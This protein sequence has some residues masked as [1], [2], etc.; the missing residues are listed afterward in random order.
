[1]RT[2][3]CS[4]TRH[5][6]PEWFRRGLARGG[7]SVRTGELLAR[8][9]LHTVCREARCPN[10]NE[11]FSRRVATFLILGDRCTR[12]CAFCNVTDHRGALPAPD[13][14]EPARLA[15]A[16]R[17]LDL[18][19]VVVT[20]VTRDDLADGG[21]AHF[22]AVITAVRAALPQAGIEVLIPD[23]RGDAD[24]LE[25]VLAARPDILNHN[26]ETVP[27]LYPQVRFHADYRRSLELLTRADRLAPDIR[28]KSGIM[29]GLGETDDEVAAVLGEMAAARVDIATIGQ[30]LR[31]S[32]AN[33]DVMRFVEPE[34]YRRYSTIGEEFGLRVF[35]G[36]YVRSS[37]NAEAVAEG[38]VPG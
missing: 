23:F 32:L 26:L 16:A 9:R 27:R 34:T 1:M 2:F 5:R 38:V 15:A 18:R 30:Y 13:P 6:L 12:N 29:V 33:H 14:E 4:P 11:C 7:Q 3:P 8:H 24:A 31:P 36:P 35:A 19:H 37:Y 21:A 22:A 20:S 17:E 25:T 28:T 10:R